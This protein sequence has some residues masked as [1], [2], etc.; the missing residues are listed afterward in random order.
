M[1]SLK[2]SPI[3]C[4]HSVFETST[5]YIL[6]AERSA[7]YLHLYL[8]RIL[9]NHNRIFK[10]VNQIYKQAIIESVE[11]YNSP[12]VYVLLSFL[13]FMLRMSRNHGCQITNK[14]MRE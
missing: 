13:V 8:I 5:T 3:V 11:A 4:L 10:S 14:N 6:L 12:P 9:V 2:F 7:L 1:F